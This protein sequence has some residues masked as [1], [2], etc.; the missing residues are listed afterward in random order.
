MKGFCRVQNTS[1]YNYV[2]DIQCINFKKNQSQFYHI[3]SFQEYYKEWVKI[4]F[5]DFQTRVGDFDKV[6]VFYVLMDVL[7]ID[8]GFILNYTIQMF[9]NVF[10]SGT[11]CFNEWKW[12]LV[13]AYGLSTVEDRNMKKL[14]KKERTRSHITWH[15][16][17]YHPLKCMYALVN[18]MSQTIRS[19]VYHLTRRVTLWMVMRVHTGYTKSIYKGEG[20]LDFCIF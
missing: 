6:G 13:G 19:N 18:N 11:F 10:D 4:L 20:K 17:I 5:N 9:S 12:I 16:L 8:W 2:L 15:F 14:N 3:F 7:L 1:K